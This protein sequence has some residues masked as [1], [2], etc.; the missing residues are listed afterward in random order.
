[1]TGVQTCALPIG[2]LAGKN[3]R[4]DETIVEL[5]DP[6][7][8]IRIEKISPVEGGVSVVLI[9]DAQLAK[10][11]MK[12]NLI[13]EVFRQYTPAP[14]ESNP[15]PQERRTSYGYLPAIPFE[16]EAAGRK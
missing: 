8:G 4:A 10:A 12:G 9:A 15:K 1:M 3:Y 7:A 5:H 11:G 14:T 2:R 16:V 13:F 6:P